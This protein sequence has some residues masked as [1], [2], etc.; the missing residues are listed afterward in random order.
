MKKKMKL[1]LKRKEENGS[2]RRKHLLA[3]KR[4]GNNTGMVPAG[5]GF[6]ESFE[7][8]SAANKHRCFHEQTLSSAAPSSVR[9]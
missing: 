8:N 5:F 6:G 1:E 4:V 9:V 3:R 2:R 7:E